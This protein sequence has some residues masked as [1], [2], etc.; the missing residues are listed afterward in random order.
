M[1]MLVGAKGEVRIPGVR[2]RGQINALDNRRCSCDSVAAGIHPSCRGRAHPH[3]HRYRR[4]RVD[5]QPDKR[6]PKLACE[7]APCKTGVRPGGLLRSAAGKCGRLKLQNGDFP[8]GAFERSR[9][10]LGLLPP[11]SA[12]PACFCHL[13]ISSIS[14][15]NC[16]TCSL[17][18]SL[19]FRN[20]IP[21]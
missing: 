5:L 2:G 20:R 6:A 9:P 14:A 7:T 21:T 1:E 19:T 4:R 13:C 11:E 10:V 3:S 15:I 8:A 16:S 17:F 12:H 18:R